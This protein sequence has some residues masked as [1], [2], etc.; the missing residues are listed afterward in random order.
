[1]AVGMPCVASNVGGIPSMIDDGKNG[2]LF[3]TKNAGM[4]AEKIIEILSNKE[5]MKRIG[6]EAK[7][8]AYERNY[9]DVVVN[10]TIKVYKEIINN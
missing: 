8:V 7:K 3:H 2:V 4:L 1:M 5:F 6:K 9:K 10:Q